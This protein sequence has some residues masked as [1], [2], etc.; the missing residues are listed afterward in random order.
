MVHASRM[1]VR[2][3]PGPVRQL[4][5]THGETYDAWYPPYEFVDHGPMAVLALCGLGANIQQVEAFH[6]TYVPR[7]RR[8]PEPGAVLNE[9]DFRSAYGDPTAYPALR[10]YFAAELVRIGTSAA[11]RRYLPELASGWVK[12]AYHPLI[13]LGYAIEFGVASEIAAGLA[14]LASNG[15][16]PA[17]AAAVARPTLIDVAALPRTADEHHIKLLYSCKTH[18]NAFSDPRYTLVAASYVTKA[19]SD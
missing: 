19:S 5:L 3:I 2:S 15:P 12:D 14:L 6:A 11:L 9:L 10:R 4:L 13:R 18:A 16:D 1:D 8:L 17:L 7:L